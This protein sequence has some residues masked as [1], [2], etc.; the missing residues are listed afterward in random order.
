VNADPKV[1]DDGGRDRSGDGR[2]DR[3]HDV[4]KGHSVVIDHPGGDHG[5]GHGHGKGKGR[6]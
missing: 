2:V 6:G 3:G 4:G 1:S 5:G